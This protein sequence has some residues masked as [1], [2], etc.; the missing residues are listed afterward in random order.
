MRILGPLLEEVWS[1]LPDVNA[2][3]RELLIE[4][5]HGIRRAD[6]STRF[7]RFTGEE[8][9]TLAPLPALPFEQV[10]WKELKVGR[11]YHVTCEYQ[12]YS[13]PFALAGRSLRARITSG[14]IT[15]F[16]GERVVA[17]HARKM[18]RKGQYST[19]PKHVPRAHQDVSALYSR[20][21]FVNRANSIGPATTQ[22]IEQLLSLIIARNDNIA[23]RDLLNTLSNA[24]IL[25]IDDFLT[26]G[27]D[28][29]ATSDLFAILANRDNQRATIIPIQPRLLAQ[30]PPR[31]HHRGLHREPHHWHRPQDQP[32]RHGYAQTNQPNHKSPTRLLGVS[33]TQRSGRRT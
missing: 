16:D 21:W 1:N 31:P 13:V 10:A 33:T 3:V 14:A 15:L 8:A 18:G 25:Q 30:S 11:N 22:V 12:H 24:D 4:I 6:G 17:E 19:D 29:R 27:I 5:N 32:R 2:A 20:A 7:E 23:H 28:E 26:T 9:A